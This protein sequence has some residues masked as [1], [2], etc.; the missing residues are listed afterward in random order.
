MDMLVNEAMG[1]LQMPDDM[2]PTG[3]VEA[4]LQF[5]KDTLLIFQEIA[6]MFEAEEKETILAICEEEKQHV[7]RLLECKQALMTS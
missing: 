5:E 3:V 4:A 1:H 6:A 7:H 2:T